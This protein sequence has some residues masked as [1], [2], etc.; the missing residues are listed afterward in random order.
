MSGVDI[1]LESL[2]T[3]SSLMRQWREAHGAGLSHLEAIPPLFDV[4]TAV[5]EQGGGEEG[6]AEGAVVG[7]YKC[8][9]VYP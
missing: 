8:N 3:L 7:L 1:D 2:L 4:A 9:P 5:R 6:G